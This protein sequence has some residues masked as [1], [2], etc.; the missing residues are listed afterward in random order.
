[1]FDFPAE[2]SRLP[3]YLNP[4]LQQPQIG[5]ENTLTAMQQLKPEELGRPELQQ[6]RAAE[7]M[8]VVVILDNVRSGLNVGAIFRTCDAFSVQSVFLCGITAHPPHA[9]IMKT[10]LGA[11][12]SVLWKT[13]P[14]VHEALDVLEAEGYHFLPVEQTSQSIFLDQFRAVDYMPA[15]L[16]FGNEMRGIED[17]V[18]KRCR[19]SIEI[20]QQGIKHSLNVATSAGIVLWEF[21]RQYRLR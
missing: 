12:E 17:S 15:A 13:F 5:I 21:F 11:T 18:L 4:T 16:I 8:P 14:H 19:Q 9:E 10:A 3:Y 6:Y 1:M 20:P 7:K 2:S